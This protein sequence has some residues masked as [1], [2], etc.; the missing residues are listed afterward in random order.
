MMSRKLFFSCAVV[1]GFCTSLFAVDQASNPFLHPLFS[2]NMV[3]QREIRTPVWGWTTP[4]ATVTVEL[5]GATA[6]CKAGSDGKWLAKLPPHKAG[7]PF[8]LKVTGPET[9]TLS[10]VML[11]DVW[12]CSG[13]SNM[14]M[15]IRICQNGDDEVAAAKYP[16]IRLFTV[17]KTMSFEPRALI[18][19]TQPSHAKWLVC[20]PDTAGA[21]GWG[22]FS[23]VG[24]FFGRELHKTLNV[25]IGLIHSSWGGTI[26]EA[27]TSAEGLKTVSDFKDKIAAFEEE[28]TKTKLNKVDPAKDMEN[29]WMKNDPGARAGWEKADLDSSDWKTMA[30][31]PKNWE[32]CGLSEFDGLV[33]F[34]KVVELPEGWANAEATLNLAMIDDMDTTF[35]NGVRVGGMDNWQAART[36]K[37]PKGILKAGR[38]VIATRALDTGGG[39]GLH[40]AP[41]S[42]N[43][44][45][46][47]QQPI[48]LAGTW[49]YKVAAPLAEMK[50]VPKRLDDHPNQTTVLYNG[51]IAPLV[52]YALKG[53]IWYQGESNAGE[54]MVY[55]RLLPAMIRDWR[56]RFGVGNFPFL[57]VQLANYMEV[58]KKPV[59]KGWALIRESQYMI[60][61]DVINCGLA[62]ATDI[63]DAADIHPQNKQEVGRR[64]ALIALAKT[65]GQQVVCSGPVYK[66]MQIKG[67]TIVLTFNDV[68]GG[69]V[70][71]GEKLLGF[72]IAGNDRNFVYADATIAGDT[73]TVSAPGVTSP[74]IV[75]YGWAN[76]PVCNLFNKEGLPAIPFRTET[77]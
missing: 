56:S 19:A 45:S 7:G 50:P 61:R 59:Q 27:W 51:M 26:A 49:Q 29:W 58:Q 34:R 18:K 30:E 16:N 4:G 75:Y 14:E 22:G 43:L 21:D 52:P 28:V 25:P 9:V 67:N 8:I 5:D 71:K 41:E 44:S 57:I 20:G 63:G 47:G 6:T 40:G 3:L 13:Q 42:M 12:L 23:A 24:Y 76:N 33:W 73:V 53:A 68:G 62:A 48:S 36:Y 65:Y 38:N 54:P 39:G 37:V 31:Q 70:A 32:Q 60:S 69:L 74:S 2:D 35:V 11:G 77:E 46:E 10:N 15:G 17:S 66:S 72:A 1:L 55:R 64:L